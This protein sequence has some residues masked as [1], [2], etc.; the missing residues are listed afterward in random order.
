VDTDPAELTIDWFLVCFDVPYNVKA[1]PKDECCPIMASIF[2]KD[3]EVLAVFLQHPKQ[4]P[5]ATEPVLERLLFRHPPAFD[6]FLG[7]IQQM[8]LVP[9]SLRHGL[10]RRNP[11]F[12]LIHALCLGSNLISLF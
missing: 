11:S 8:Q 3:G 10:N 5:D 4:A 2:H 6:G 7:S 9:V 12:L 1:T